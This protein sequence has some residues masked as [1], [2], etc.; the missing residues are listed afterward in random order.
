MIAT[1]SNVQTSFADD[2]DR[3]DELFVQFQKT[4]RSDYARAKEF[5]KEFKFGLQRH[6][7]WEESILFPL[8]EKKTGMYHTGPTEVMRQEHRRIGALLEAIHK[9]VQKQDPESDAEEKALLEALLA[10]NQ[11][12]E[13][14]LYPAIDRLTTDEDKNE[15]FAAMEKVPEEAY[16]TCCGKH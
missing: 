7:V 8:F 10:H 14:V 1:P 3:L 4:K 5:F 6:I 12:E 9:K 11:K 15:A 16:K 2:H 13:Q